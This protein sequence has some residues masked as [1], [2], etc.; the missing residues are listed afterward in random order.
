MDAS[1][2]TVGR[3]FSFVVEVSKAMVEAFAQAT[4]D[5][6]PIHFDITAAKCAGFATVIAH[7]DLIAP[8]ANQLIVKEFPGIVLLERTVSFRRAV[9]VGSC[10]RI[11]AILAALES[12]QRG[13]NIHNTMT[14]VI[15]Y[16][17]PVGKLC[18]SSQVKA[19][20][21]TQ[22]TLIEAELSA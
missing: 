7:G 21:I 14:F 20:L 9:P 22:E 11:E 12:S 17:T 2:L 18:I 13:E 15:R 5:H 10:I 6:N 3:E 4:G 1:K 19:L 8:L 16:L